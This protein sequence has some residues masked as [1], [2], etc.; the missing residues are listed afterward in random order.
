MKYIIDYDLRAPG[1]NY[2][3]LITAIKAYGSWAKICKSTWAIKSDSSSAAIRDN[4]MQY[5]DKN[6]V[7]FVAAFSGWSS[8]NLPKDVVDWLNS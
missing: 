5:I 6:D 4:L 8:L 2:D 3:D 7:L 1:R